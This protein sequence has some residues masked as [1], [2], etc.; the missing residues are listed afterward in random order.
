MSRWPC[1]VARDHQEMGRGDHS[2]PARIADTVDSVPTRIDEHFAI[3]VGG[4][5]TPA[6]SNVFFQPHAVPVPGSE[7]AIHNAQVASISVGKKDVPRK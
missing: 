4:K 6:R 7:D 2:R 5:K 3:A 1:V